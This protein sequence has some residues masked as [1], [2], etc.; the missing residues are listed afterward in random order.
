[1]GYIKAANRNFVAGWCKRGIENPS[2]ASRIAHLPTRRACRNCRH[3][4][5]RHRERR[6][7]RRHRPPV[8]RPPSYWRRSQQCLRS[9][10]GSEPTRRI[11]RRRRRDAYDFRAIWMSTIMAQRRAFLSRRWTTE[12]RRHHPRHRPCR[13]RERMCLDREVC[14]PTKSPARLPGVCKIFIL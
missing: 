10:L 8:R 13:Y 14:S 4:R 7:R 12:T 6:F 5:G 1:M 3:P 2:D 11:R 9:V